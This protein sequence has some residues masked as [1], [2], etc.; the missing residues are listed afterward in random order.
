MN[1]T[2]LA[3]LS[4]PIPPQW[5]TDAIATEACSACP[6]CLPERRPQCHAIA[7]QQAMAACRAIRERAGVDESARGMYPDNE[8]AETIFPTSDNGEVHNDY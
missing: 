2:L 1:T 8:S 6:E 4:G 3:E 5:L 7:A